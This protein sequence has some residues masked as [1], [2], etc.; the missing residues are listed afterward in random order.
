MN[1]TTIICPHCKKPFEISDAIQHQI[2]DELLR[3][4]AEQ[5]ETLRKEFDESS[6]ARIKQAVQKALPEAN[7]N[8]QIQLERECIFTPP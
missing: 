4:K 1:S 7:Q 6:E 2:E 5:S 8:A 3:A